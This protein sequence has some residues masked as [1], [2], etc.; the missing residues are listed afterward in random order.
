MIAGVL[1]GRSVLIEDERSASRLRNRGYLG[2]N[3]G[4]MLLLNLPVAL[5]LVRSGK[6]E[7]TAQGRRVGEEE[8]KSRMSGDEVKLFQAYSC[9]RRGG[10]NPVFRGRKLMWNSLGVMP[11][12]GTE[13]IDLS[14]LARRGYVLVLDDGGCILYSYELLFRGEGRSLRSFLEARGFRVES[15]LKYGCEYRLYESIPHASFLLNRET[16]PRAKD[17]VARVRIAHSVR[18]TYVQVA[19]VEGEFL[20]Y[21]FQWIR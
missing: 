8:L 2:K 21:S 7:V 16:K 11:F 17:I 13:R 10:K 14:V 5:Y 3:I 6:M 20:G 18:K 1:R 12:C 4:T 15:G 9:L 19:K